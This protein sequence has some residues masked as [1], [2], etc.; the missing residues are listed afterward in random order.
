MMVHFVPNLYPFPL[1]P[2][3]RIETSMEA[4]SALQGIIYSDGSSPTSKHDIY[5]VQIRF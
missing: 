3:R 4:H 1:L 2:R 5:F